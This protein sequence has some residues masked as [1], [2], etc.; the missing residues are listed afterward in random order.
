VLRKMRKATN[1]PWVF[2]T[3]RSGPLSVDA[4]QYYPESLILRGSGL[5][6]RPDRVAN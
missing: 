4:M 2:E 1:G 3:E 6:D 5:T